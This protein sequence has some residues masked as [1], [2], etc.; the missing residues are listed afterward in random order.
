MKKNNIKWTFQR[1]LP[2]KII[3]HKIIF[4]AKKL[5][6]T[7]QSIASTGGGFDL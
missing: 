4:I 3:E 5:L 1:K 6:I 2:C 7:T